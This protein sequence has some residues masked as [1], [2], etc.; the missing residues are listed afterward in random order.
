M[1][2]ILCVAVLVWI[3]CLSLW[4]VSLLER[5]LMR[6][7]FKER[8]REIILNLKNQISPEEDTSVFIAKHEFYN[9]LLEAVK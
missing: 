2:I 7:V 3:V 8:Q 5:R 4:S 9:N 6:Q 1:N